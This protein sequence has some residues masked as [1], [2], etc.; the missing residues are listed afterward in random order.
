MFDNVRDLLQGT[1][2][3]GDMKE[4]K[5][6]YTFLK[7]CPSIRLIGVKEYMDRFHKVTVNYVYDDCINGT[8][9]IRYKPVTIQS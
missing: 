9:D 8:I 7:T 1:I 5:D 2:E 3:I 4:I 6:V